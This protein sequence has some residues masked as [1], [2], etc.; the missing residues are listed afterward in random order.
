MFTWYKPFQ[1]DREDVAV[2]APT[3]YVYV[4]EVRKMIM[5]DRRSTVREVTDFVGIR[6][7]LSIY[8]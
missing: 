1:E 3:I 8:N 5:N 2:D 4:K 7:N 6:V